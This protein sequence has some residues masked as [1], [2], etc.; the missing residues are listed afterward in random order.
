MTATGDELLTTSH[1]YNAC[2]NAMDFVA[3]RSGA[4]VV[5]VDV[6]FPIGSSDEVVERVLDGASDK[7][8]L[9]VVDHITSLREN[10][11]GSRRARD[12]D[13]GG[14]CPRSRDATA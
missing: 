11:P 12:R 14:R 4:R 13:A 8:R 6:P 2:R 10:R 5:A 9:A 3:G 7:T 1:E